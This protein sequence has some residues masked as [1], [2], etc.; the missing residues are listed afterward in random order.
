MTVKN[1]NLSAFNELTNT[2]IERITALGELNLKVAEKVAARQMQ[3][4]NLFMEQGVRLLQLATDAKGYSDYYKGQV[5]LA[6]EISDRMMAE[7]KANLQ[8]A[9]E[10]RDEYRNW[11]DAMIADVRNSKDV[12]RNAVMA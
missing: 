3:A 9:A 6:K 4:M 7:S 11:F 10:T 1:N 12:V 5:D 2:S 8:V